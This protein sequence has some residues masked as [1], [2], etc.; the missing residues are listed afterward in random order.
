MFSPVCIELGKMRDLVEKLPLKRE[1]VMFDR[2]FVI[3]I[4]GV[5]KGFI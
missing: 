1:R 4:V 5:L 2:A 3:K